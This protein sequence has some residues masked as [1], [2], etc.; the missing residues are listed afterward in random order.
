MNYLSV[1]ELA[2]VGFRSLGT[3]VLVSRKASIYGAERLQVGSHVRIDDYCVL[4][5]GTGGISIGDFVHIG[6]LCGLYGEA[7]ITIGDFCGLSSRVALYSSSDDFTGGSLTNPTVPE[8]LR[9]VTS[10]PIVMHRHGLVGSGSTLLPGTTL[11]EGAAVGAMS[12]VRGNLKEFTIYQG[13][14][15]K[16]LHARGRRALELEAECRRRFADEAY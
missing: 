3:D 15:A 1:G 7:P 6:P 14:P 2:E 13:I 12:L 5:A 8:D 4:S 9:R 10:R 16:P 11:N